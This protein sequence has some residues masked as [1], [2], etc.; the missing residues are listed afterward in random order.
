MKINSYYF[1]GYWCKAEEIGMIPDGEEAVFID[2]TVICWRAVRENGEY[3]FCGV[4]MDGVTPEMELE[5]VARALGH[6]DEARKFRAE[7]IKKYFKFADS[8][9]WDVVP[10]SLID[11]FRWLAR[12]K[13]VTGPRSVREW[14]DWA[15]K[16]VWSNAID[17]TEK[18]RKFLETN[19]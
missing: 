3:K 19:K 16:F 6:A 4:E 10:D 2:G 13:Y 7:W 12:N 8:L 17:L 9:T 1:D 14:D 15:K 5:C 18:G 11:G